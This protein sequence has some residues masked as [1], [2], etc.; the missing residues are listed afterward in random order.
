MPITWPLVH[1]VDP[2][3]TAL[4]VVNFDIVRFEREIWQTNKT[5]IRCS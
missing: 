1:V 4:T 5:V 3:A 2:K